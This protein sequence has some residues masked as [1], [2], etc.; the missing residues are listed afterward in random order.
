MT[1]ARLE[2]AYLINANL[3]HCLVDNGSDR[4]VQPAQGNSLGALDGAVLVNTILPDGRKVT[5]AKGKEYLQKK[6]LEEVVK[7]L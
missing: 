7:R 1:G 4:P 6:E 5:N 2:G 3:Y